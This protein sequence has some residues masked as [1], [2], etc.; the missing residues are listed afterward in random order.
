MRAALTPDAL[1]SF[2]KRVGVGDALKQLSAYAPMANMRSMLD[3]LEPDARSQLQ[4]T[5]DAMPSAPLPPRRALVP[6]RAREPQ[7]IL[8]EWEE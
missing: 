6:N 8:E 5:L 2:A 1:A 7:Q 4:S 3:K